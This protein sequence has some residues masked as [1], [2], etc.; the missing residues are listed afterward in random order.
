MKIKLQSISLRNFKG[1]KDFIFSPM[2]QSAVISG[3]NGAGKT[4]VLDAFLWLLTNNNSSGEADFG[5]KT[6]TENGE[7]EQNLEHSVEALLI[8]D[9]APVGKKLRKVYMEKWTKKRGSR[10]E[11]FSGHETAYYI[12]DVPKSKR[13]YDDYIASIAP[14][15]MFRLLTSVGYFNAMKWQD[16]RALLLEIVGDVSDSRVIASDD[17][18]GELPSILSGKTVDEYRKMAKA[19]RAKMNTEI[20]ALPA[21]IDEAQR[22]KPGDASCIPPQGESYGDLQ[23]R[24]YNLQNDRAAMLAGDTKYINAKIAAL[25]DESRERIWKYRQQQDEAERERNGFVAAANELKGKIDAANNRV[26]S[27]KSEAD[28]L[29]VE[30]VKLREEYARIKAAPE[31]VSGTCPTCGQ[32]MPEEM[33]AEAISAFRAKKADNLKRIQDEGKKKKEISDKLVA[34]VEALL[35]SV[36]A[37]VDELSLAAESAAA[38]VMP[39]APDTSDIDSRIAEIKAQKGSAV[40]DTAKIDAEVEKVQGLIALHNEAAANVRAAAQCDERVKE[41]KTTQKHLG[42]E[43][44]ELDRRLLLMEEFVRAKVSMLTDSVNVKFCPLRFRLFEEQINGGLAECCETMVPSPDG[45]LVPWQD[46]NTGGRI[47][48]GLI[49]IDRLIAHFGISLPIWIDNAESV[50]GTMLEPDAQVIKLVAS[51]DDWLTVKLN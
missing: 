26:F 1:V 32:A 39:E 41:L 19:Q 25:Q 33:L 8:I 50:V 6:T 13:E 15:G 9:N 22:A 18:F 40:P 35:D 17:R 49:I 30:M 43:I 44:D 3:P 20:D 38:V 2:S 31:P 4:T 37:M 45:N 10:V 14:K 48:A 5:I 29:A 21:R 24:L 12:D 46:V 23:S 11:E 7:A 28:R 16:R 36:K 42:V 27:H 34:E 51:G 47:R